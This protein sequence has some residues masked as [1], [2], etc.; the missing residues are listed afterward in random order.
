[1]ITQKLRKKIYDRDNWECVA[2]GTPAG[3]TIQH[4]K[5][6]Q[7]GGSKSLDIPE[8]LITMCAAH[9]QALEA[10]AEFAE[11]GRK[12]GWKIRQWDDPA[13]YPVRYPDGFFYTLTRRFTRRKHGE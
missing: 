13:V 7:M 8:N 2:C 6:R 11:Y 12:K 9:N 5:N 4:R 1:M 10:N 3:L